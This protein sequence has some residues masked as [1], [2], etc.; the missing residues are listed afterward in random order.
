MTLSPSE[1]QTLI[2]PLV[3]GCLLGAF[4]AYAVFAF[5]SEFE[6]QNGESID[7]W[8]TAAE[9]F[10]AFLVAAA[11]TVGLLGVLPI[12][13]QRWRAKGGGNV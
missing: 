9:A 6:L 13:V 1:K 7:K 8:Q 12:V 10:F 11:A 2:G 4:V 3:V 5:A